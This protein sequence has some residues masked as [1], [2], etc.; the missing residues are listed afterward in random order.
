MVGVGPGTGVVVAVEVQERQED[1]H[2]RKVLVRT[3]RVPDAVA[4]VAPAEPRRSRERMSPT[5]AAAVDQVDNRALTLRLQLV[6]RGAREVVALLDLL[7]VLA[8]V[9]R[10]LQALAEQHRR[11]VVAVQVDTATVRRA[12]VQAPQ[13]A[14]MAGRE[15]SSFA[16]P[17]QVCL[18]PILQ[19]TRTPARRRQT[20][21]PT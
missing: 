6:D 4:T 11:V 5:A 3:C 18:N 9:I 13:R 10:L 17:F 15:L 20:T 8:V 14:E 19:L 1:G 21:S 16:M 12:V 2:R 7:L